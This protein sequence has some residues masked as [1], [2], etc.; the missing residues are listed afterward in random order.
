MEERTN[1]K[2]YPVIGITTGDPAGIGPEITVKALVER[3]WQETLRP[4]VVGDAAVIRDVCAGLGVDREVVTVDSPSEAVFDPRLIEV[5]DCQMV[6][7]V[8]YGT[9]QPEYGAAA[10]RYIERVVE[11]AQ[12]GEIDGMV[13]GPINKE[14]AWAGGSQFPG[15]TE[16]LANLFGVPEDDVVT[17][18]VLEQLRIF[19]LT[20]HLSLR[21]AIDALSTDRTVAFI[22]RVAYLIREL[23]G[24]GSRLALAGL[25]PHAGENGKMGT[26]ELEILAPAVELAR[27]RGIDVVGPVPADAVFFQ[28]RNGAY[29]G[30]IS[31]F[32]DQ[33]HIAAK[34]VDF[35]GTVACQLGLPVLRTTVDHGTAFDIAGTWVANAHGQVRAMETCAELGP[36]VLAAQRSLAESET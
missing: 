19:F 23:D 9:V 5:V 22:E 6:E 8:V 11:L 10:I 28:G 24:E 27:Q 30:V 36:R 16:M 34:T 20:R 4:V 14:S 21:K 2:E 26:E 32:H 25:N 12:A 15:H 18:F 1:A 31:L 3:D 17:M 33:G 7:D 29:G 13:T 35:F